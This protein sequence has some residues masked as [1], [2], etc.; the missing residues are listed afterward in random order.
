MIIAQIT[1]FHL[2]AFGRHA[3]RG[4]DTAACLALAVAQLAALD[5][6]PDCVVATGDLT[7]S[8]RPEEYELLR[9]LLAP[10]H[11]P[12][13]LIPGNHDDREALR[14]AFADK[15][16]IP[17]VGFLDYVV[18]AHA[19]RLVALDTLVPGRSGG[20]L[21]KE[22]LERLDRTLAEARHRPT[23]IIMH[24]P[25]F[26]TGIAHMDAIGLDGAEA[27][28]AVLARHPQVQRVLCGHLHRAIQTVLAPGAIASTAPST[29]HQVRLDLRPDG[30]ADYILEPPGYQLHV[31]DEGGACVS[32][33][34]SIGGFDGPY[35]FHEERRDA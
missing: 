25:P 3:Y 6:A 18:D 20:H 10:L 26:R 34:G 35:P 24:H 8:G 15:P 23:A 4:V 9:D 22:R 29:A 13:Y 27:F 16:Y 19:V 17:A 28:A 32:H 14:R 2:T 31:W 12:V 11:A 30:P 5:P 1:D 7:E 33:T 21:E